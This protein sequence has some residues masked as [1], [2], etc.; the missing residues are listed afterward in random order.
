MYK[1]SDNGLLDRLLNLVEL[2]QD[3]SG[4]F[5][6]KQ[7]NLNTSF[8]KGLSL[9]FQKWLENLTHRFPEIIRMIEI[10][11]EKTDTLSRL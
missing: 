8:L 3:W 5:R 11:A 10:S 6:K 4:L 7:S 9:N 1:I 2:H